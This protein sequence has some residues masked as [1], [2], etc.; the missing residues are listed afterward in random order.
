M[1]KLRPRSVD[2]EL[3]P[4]SIV[5]YVSQTPT[6]S[7]KQSKIKQDK[8]SFKFPELLCTVETKLYNITFNTLL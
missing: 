5:V 4:F 1:A 3:H 6:L 2:S 8:N 7:A